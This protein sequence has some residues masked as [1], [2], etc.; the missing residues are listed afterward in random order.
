MVRLLIEEVREA[1][2]RLMDSDA[3]FL[4]KYKAE[5]SLATGMLAAPAIGMLLKEAED[6]CKGLKTYL[7]PIRND[8]FGEKITVSGLLT[9][10]DILAQLKE[11]ELGERLLLPANILR[12]GEDVLLDDVRLPEISEKLNVPIATTG[13]SGYDFVTT[14]F[15]LPKGYLGG[16]QEDDAGANPYELQTLDG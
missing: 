3:D 2:R 11:R 10:R 7:Y 16:D 13:H 15:E 8:F 6:I 1:Y 9:G 12:S 4:K 5:V 14:L